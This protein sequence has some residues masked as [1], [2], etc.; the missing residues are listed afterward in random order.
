MTMAQDG[1]KFVSLTHRPPLPTGNTPGTHFFWRLSWTQGHSAIGW[2]LGQWK[3]PLTPAGIEPVTFRFVAQHRN[4]WATGFKDGITVNFNLQKI[5]WLSFYISVIYLL[6]MC[7]LIHKSVYY[8][9]P[10]T[11][12]IYL[13]TQT[14]SQNKFSW[15]H[16]YRTC[17]TLC[18]NRKLSPY[19]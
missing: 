5:Y 1:G 6:Y 3:T 14:L 8:T 4:R 9:I 11:I 7:I 17:L 13:H 12:C 16:K 10:V 2:N 19:L 18:V 15:I